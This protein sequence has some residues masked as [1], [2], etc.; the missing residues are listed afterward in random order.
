M[1]RKLPPAWLMGFFGNLPI[2]VFG[3]IMLMTVPQLL[4]AEHVPEPQIAAITA[5][6]LATGFC[7]FLLAPILDWRFRRRSYAVGLLLVTALLQF[8]ALM[9]VHNLALLAGFLF[10]GALAV[11]LALSAVS[12]WLGGLVSDQNK[13]QLGAWYSVASIAGYGVTAVLAITLLRDLPYIVGAG[14]LSLLLLL[15]LAMLYPFLP[16]PPADRRLARESFGQFVRD[17]LLL[18][19]RREVLWTL[20]LFVLPAAS[21]ALTNMLGA[22]AHD[23]GTSERA[24]SVVAGT[25]VSAA[26]VV[27]ALTV[28]QLLRW[29][30]PR[31]LYLVIG[32]SGAIFTL[33]LILLPHTQGVF[34][35]AMLA[36]NLFQAAAFAVAF[37][38]K[39]R[40]IG[41]DNPFAATQFALLN[42]A[43]NVPLSYMQML[44]GQ[45]YGLG[46]LKGAALTDGML[47][48]SA[49]CLLALLFWHKGRR[50][51][52]ASASL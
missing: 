20:L 19:S 29:V 39:L 1:E 11:H 26:G 13:G 47:T 6:G 43:T 32:G 40:G 24:A 37:T 22:I 52:T 36:E 49:C 38:I 35:L 9:A 50:R 45:A 21:F 23:F 14:L 5:L 17:L 34:I 33:C 18:L 15:P 44:D 4:A 16:A 3:A 28:P 31:R 46:G 42:A 41:N 7:S 27:G 30:G 10:A 25:G 2:G 48:L 8:A 12:G 51:V